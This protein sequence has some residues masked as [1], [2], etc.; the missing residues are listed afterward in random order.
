MTRLSNQKTEKRTPFDCDVLQS[1]VIILHNVIATLT[2]P[3]LILLPPKN[4][5]KTSSCS[6]GVSWELFWMSQSMQICVKKFAKH[7][8]CCEI[9]VALLKC[10]DRDTPNWKYNQWWHLRF[11]E[12]II[13][14][15]LEFLEWKHQILPNLVDQ[16]PATEFFIISLYGLVSL[17]VGD[18]LI[19][20]LIDW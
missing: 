6:T 15:H 3:S 9:N 12:I 19:D 14:V 1:I 8:A 2:P 5:K 16:T 18:N 10:S 11:Q 17:C 4:Y 13:R 20:C 7:D